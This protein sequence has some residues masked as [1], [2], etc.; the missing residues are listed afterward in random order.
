MYAAH[1][2]TESPARQDVEG[3]DRRLRDLERRVDDR[4]AS[5]ESKLNAIDDLL[6]AVRTA[7]TN[8]TSF[9]INIPG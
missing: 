8:G 9:E 1:H 7:T 6:S 3:M 5:V 4:M 2:E